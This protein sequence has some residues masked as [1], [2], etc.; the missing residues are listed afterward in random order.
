MTHSILTAIYVIQVSSHRSNKIV[1]DDLDLVIC[2]NPSSIQVCGASTASRRGRRTALH[3]LDKLSAARM[4][5]PVRS[6]VMT[7]LNALLHRVFCL[8]LSNVPCPSEIDS[9]VQVD[10]SEQWFPEKI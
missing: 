4:H 7:T 1:S 10:I 5:T 6:S 2:L 3:S 9:N 8:F